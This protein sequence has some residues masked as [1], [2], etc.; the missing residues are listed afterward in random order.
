MVRCVILAYLICIIVVSFF[1]NPLLSYAQDT[2]QIDKNLE[3]IS[4][5]Y[6]ECAAYYRLVS[7]AMETSNELKSADTY[8]Q[9]EGQAGL[10]SILLA[11]EGRNEEM[12]FKV[13][14][15][16]IEMYI[17]QMRQETNNRNENISVL[18]NKYHF[19]C[20]EAMDNLPKAVLEILKK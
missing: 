12:A 16:R 6:A 20:Q 1:V 14:Q 5:Q 4:G 15:S 18:I 11:S 9:L 3:N 8:R 10:Y 2:K 7:Y 19:E 17:K 13:T